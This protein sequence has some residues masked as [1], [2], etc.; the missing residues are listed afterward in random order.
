MEVND[1]G[2]RLLTFATANGL[3]I[4]NSIFQHKQK[5]QRTWRAPNGS[6]S[7]L[8]DYV[9]VSRGFRTSINDVE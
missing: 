2:I 3:L 6:E 7:A 8:L 1:N 4:E 9:L 5:H